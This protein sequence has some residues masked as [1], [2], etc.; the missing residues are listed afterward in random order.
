MQVRDPGDWATG[1][2]AATDLA[3]QEG[4]FDGGK[5]AS[6]IELEKPLEKMKIRTQR[7]RATESA[8]YSSRQEEAP[9]L[10]S[11]AEPD[12]PHSVVT[13]EAQIAAIV[14]QMTVLTEAVKNL[15]QDRKSTRLNS[16]HSGESRMPSSA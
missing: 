4:V 7:S 5:T 3:R 2:L 10:P 16:S 14:R 1:G 6:S 11:I 12:S 15:Q 8:R 13:T 9:P